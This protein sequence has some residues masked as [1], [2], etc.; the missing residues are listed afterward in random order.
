MPKSEPFK[1]KAKFTAEYIPAQLCQGKEWYIYLY[2]RDPRADDPTKLKRKRF[3]VNRIKNTKERFRFAMVQIDKFNRLLEQ[4]WSPWDS[5]ESSNPNYTVAEGLQEFLRVRLREVKAGSKRT[6]ISQAKLILGYLNERRLDRAR[7]REFDKYAARALMDHLIDVLKVNERTY[8]NRLVFCRMV[9]KWMVEEDL[10]THN[11]FERIRKLKVPKKKRVP[12]PLEDRIRIRDYFKEHNPPMLLCMYL[13]AYT[14]LR[15]AEMTRIRVR[16]FDLQN[17]IIRVN[18]SQTKSGKDRY[19]TIPN[20]FADFLRALDWSAYEPDHYFIGRDW[21]PGTEKLE[22]RYISREWGVMREELGMPMK[23]QF[24]SLRDTGIGLMLQ[25][26]VKAHETMTQA[27]HSDLTMM[28]HYTDFFV[29]V[30]NE[31]IKKLDGWK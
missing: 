6:Y 13:L 31:D 9:W 18:G 19:P 2:A 25:S 14:Q 7:I 3:K 27:G 10:A 24:Y 15:P 22:S 21:C 5:Q 26:G 8:N 17:Q 29:P 1:S 20:V 12:I 11:P 16:D 4:G 30:A 23:Y 28:K